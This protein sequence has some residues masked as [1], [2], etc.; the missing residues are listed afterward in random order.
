MQPLPYFSRLSAAKNNNITQE[1]WAARNLDAAT[2]QARM[3]LRTWPYNMTTII[4]PFGCDLQPQIPKHSI[5][6]RTHA[7]PKQLEATVTIREQK[8]IKTNGPQPPRTRGAPLH[9]RL[10]PLYPKKHN[11]PRSSFNPKTNP[12]QHSCCHYKAICNHFPKPPLPSVTTSLS[13]H[14]P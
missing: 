11:V 9:R 7:H 4:Q 2:W 8:N 10:Q 1:T 14:F 5:T 6:T 12:M 13:H 3:Y